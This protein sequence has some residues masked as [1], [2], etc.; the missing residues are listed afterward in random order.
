MIIMK[1]IC[2]W[3]L[4]KASF[5]RDMIQKTEN[6]LQKIAFLRI[7]FN[8]ASKAIGLKFIEG[9]LFQFNE[10]IHP[11]I[12]SNRRRKFL[13]S[14]QLFKYNDTRLILPAL[15][16]RN[17]RLDY[18][19]QLKKISTILQQQEYANKLKINLSIISSI[20]FN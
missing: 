12:N 16:S 7:N 14:N 3:L 10:S 17:E 1:T 6:D 11:R 4:S 5:I 13:S 20:E 18:F 2:N 8:N 15:N 19:S 9:K